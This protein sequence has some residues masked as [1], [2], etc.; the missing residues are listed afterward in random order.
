MPTRGIQLY[1]LYCNY[2]QQL[3]YE[4]PA[5]NEPPTDGPIT[6]L[7]LRS[8]VEFLEP[9]SLPIT[10]SV[11][12]R[13]LIHCVQVVHEVPRIETRSLSLDSLEFSLL[14]PNATPRITPLSSECTP[15]SNCVHKRLL[16]VLMAVRLTTE[17]QSVS[18]HSS[19]RAIMVGI[20][21]VTQMILSL[22]DCQIR[23]H[24]YTN[25]SAA[26]HILDVYI[27]LV[28]LITSNRFN[29]PS[30]V[31]TYFDLC[32]IHRVVGR[33]VRN[34]DDCTWIFIATQL[35]RG[36]L[37]ILHV[38]LFDIQPTEWNSTWCLL[39]AKLAGDSKYWTMYEVCVHE[40]ADLIGRRVASCCGADTGTGTIPPSL[41]KF[42]VDI[43]HKHSIR[44][45]LL[46]D[47]SFCFSL[48]QSALFSQIWSA[49]TYYFGYKS[50]PHFVPMMAFLWNKASPSCFLAFLRD[51]FSDLVE[52]IVKG[53]CSALLISRL[54]NFAEHIES[55]LTNSTR[56]VFFGCLFQIL[57]LPLCIHPNH[58]S[59]SKDNGPE[60]FAA[61][62]KLWVYALDQSES[63]SPK[64]MDLAVASLKCLDATS[65]YQLASV[66]HESLD[67]LSDSIEHFSGLLLRQITLAKPKRSNYLWERLTECV[68]QL[69]MAYLQSCSQEL[70]NKS[71]ELIWHNLC[72]LIVAAQYEYSGRSAPVISFVKW[73]FMNK[74]HLRTASSEHTVVSLSLT[75]LQLVINKECEHLECLR[76]EEFAKWCSQISALLWPSLFILSEA[77]AEGVLTETD[78][79]STPLLMDLFSERFC[80]TIQVLPNASSLLAGEI[81]PSLSSM[82]P[83]SLPE[84]TAFYGS[85]RLLILL[86]RVLIRFAPEARPIASMSDVDEIVHHPD[87]V[88]LW[89]RCATQLSS[90]LFLAVQ[91]CSSKQLERDRQ[92]LIRD[93][94]A[95]LP[96]RVSCSALS[97]AIIDILHAGLLGRGSSS[98]SLQLSPS[99]LEKIIT[100][101]RDELTNS[102]NV[103]CVG[104]RKA[105]FSSI[106]KLN[107]ITTA[108]FCTVF[109]LL[110]LQLPIPTRT[111]SP[112][113][114]T[115]PKVGPVAW[116][117]Q[118]IH[119]TGMR[120]PDQIGAAIFNKEGHVDLFEQQL[121]WP[122][123]AT[124]LNLATEAEP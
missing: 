44:S 21:E 22:F 78:H 96:A 111:R 38:G 37:R 9:R 108:I 94:L 26:L 79:G 107:Q 101:I 82:L 109:Q 97:D 85:P 117:Y 15:A 64:S 51:F 77:H 62:L 58:F 84:T 19:L 60:C 123:A 73:Q 113:L 55:L 74:L 50:N 12:E 31:L 36:I 66:V 75:A 24:L 121:S 76:T 13:N 1:P 10:Q 23:T 100:I 90:R 104:C 16:R 30:R 119:V 34:A 48:Y 35:Q 25:L 86:L 39:F 103:V 70:P 118:F 99:H 47:V 72:R 14:G 45:I 53:D 105:S 80:S 112:H 122:L 46:N 65:D 17:D 106:R 43:I 83:A 115:A 7:G 20:S 88:D 49:L 81:L 98:T 92:L 4:E 69:S 5:T 2:C 54:K 8:S 102:T 87:D 91:N 120:K 3:I 57:V 67:F 61:F 18:F 63:F 40:L 93:A 33:I 32:P 42:V 124:Y 11:S 68:V 56:E 27:L 41:A 116:L 28:N 59:P 71:A 6:E 114:C 95:I 110:N 52:Q 29:R 89:T